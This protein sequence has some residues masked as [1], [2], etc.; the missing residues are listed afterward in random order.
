MKDPS[1]LFIGSAALIYVVAYMHGRAAGSPDGA[2]HCSCSEQSRT[3]ILRQSVDSHALAECVLHDRP[4]RGVMHGR[5][6]RCFGRSSWQP[7][8]RS[9]GTSS[10]GSSREGSATAE[11]VDEDEFEESET[12][13][14]D[15]SALAKSLD[16]A[17]S[18]G[19]EAASV[20]GTRSDTMS[21]D[22]R[23]IQEHIEDEEDAVDANKASV[24]PTVVAAAAAAATAAVAAATPDAPAAQQQAAPAPGATHAEPTDDAAPRASAVTVSA[25]YSN[26]SSSSSSSSSSSRGGGGSGGSE[27]KRVIT[28][29]LYG[30]TPKY[31]LGAV[32]N[33]ELIS[34]IFPGWIARYYVDLV[35]VPSE[36]VAALRK[37]GAELVPIDMTRHGNQS[38]F[39]RFWAAADPTVERFISRDVDSRLM[40]RDAVAVAQWVRSDAPFHVVRDHP[41]HS[42]YPMSGGLWGARRGALPQVMDLINR[43]PTDSKYL[44][45]MLF[46]NRDVWPIAMRD[47]VLQHDAFTCVEFDDALGF[48][49]A[50]DAKGFHV[51]QVFDAEGKG[52]QVDID[53]LLKARQPEACKPGGD[54]SKARGSRAQIAPENECAQ[55]QHQHHVR[56]GSTWG[57]LPT[58]LQL[59]WQRLACDG[60][61]SS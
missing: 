8:V 27:P 17:V 35:S 53:L 24:T 10:S 26:A 58:P 20:S 15:A 57:S 33:A 11:P 6:S 49:V 16:N 29:S 23:A 55:L 31:V 32:R 39:W 25:A 37:L 45:D 61:V 56:P 18:E 14:E 30:R 52:R 34:T 41:S 44:T 2:V 22:V 7:P 40:E 60:R 12:P 54:P 5:L 46:L 51:G 59:R 13:D 21:A 38:M 47:G 28:Y 1:L 50:V 36:I 42:L 9:S 48:P 19:E 3:L 4:T 43:F